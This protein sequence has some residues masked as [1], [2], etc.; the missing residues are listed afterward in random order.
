MPKLLIQR[1]GC[2]F[3]EEEALNPRVSRRFFSIPQT[4]LQITGFL[5]IN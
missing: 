4:F 5:Y 3:L 1:N 2:C